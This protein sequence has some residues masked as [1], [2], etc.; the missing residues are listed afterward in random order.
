MR[1]GIL[2]TLAILTYIQDSISWVL[3]F[4]IPCIAMLFSLV[5]FLLGTKTYGFYV[6]EDESLFVQISKTLVSLAR[7]RQERFPIISEETGETVQ[8]K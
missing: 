8:Y 5:V 1:G 3:G 2:V 4:G 6:L 7:R